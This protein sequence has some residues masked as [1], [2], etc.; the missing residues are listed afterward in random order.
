MIF[1]IRRFRVHA[2]KPIPRIRRGVHRNALPCR[3]VK[4]GERRKLRPEAQDV[5]VA[6][7]AANIDPAA[8]FGCLENISGKAEILVTV[9]AFIVE[10]D[11]DDG[12]FL[13]SFGKDGEGM[14]EV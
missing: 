1:G 14:A 4:G 10:A 12:F 2:L 3:E 6:A 13:P 11:F 9:A 7:S 5:I 8:I